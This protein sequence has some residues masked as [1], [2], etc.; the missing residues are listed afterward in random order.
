MKN[1]FRLLHNLEEHTSGDS[2]LHESKAVQLSA[3]TPGSFFHNTS[4]SSPSISLFFPLSICFSSNHP[5]VVLDVVCP[6]NLLYITPALLLLT[7]WSLFLNLGLKKETK[8]SHPQKA[9][10]PFLPSCH[11][12]SLLHHFF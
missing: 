11:P 10:S 1:I 9:V 3:Q 7:G 4:S 12:L 8:P 2:S 5:S 6:S